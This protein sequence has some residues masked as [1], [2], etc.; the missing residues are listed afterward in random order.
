MALNKVLFTVGALAVLATGTTIALMADQKI[1]LK[2]TGEVVIEEHI[3]YT[4]TAYGEVITEA[5]C[6]KRDIIITLSDTSYCLNGE[7]LGQIKTALYEEYTEKKDYDFDINNREL[8]S[9]VLNYEVNANN[10]T[11]E[12]ITD[13]EELK[14]QL[15]ELLNPNN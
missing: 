4:G 6:L 14:R 10:I 5:P 12:N 15:V 13:K 9:E 1:E 8:L 2:N 7:E 11:F 3:I